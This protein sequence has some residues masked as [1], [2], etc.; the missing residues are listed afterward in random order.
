MSGSF[1]RAG[2][3]L[4][5]VVSSAG[6]PAAAE[7][8]AG[9]APPAAARLDDAPQELLL[10]LVDPARPRGLRLAALHGLTGR[11]GAA[12]D[13]ALLELLG[14]E[15]PAVRAV[16]VEAVAARAARGDGGVLVGLRRAVAAGGSPATNRRA[17]GA[18]AALAHAAPGGAVPELAAAV[19]HPC[20]DVRGAALLGLAHLGVARST[21]AAVA[22]RPGP[23]GPLPALAVVGPEDLVRPASRPTVDAAPTDQ[24]PAVR[25]ALHRALAAAPARLPGRVDERGLILRALAAWGDPSTCLLPVLETIERDPACL[26]PGRAALRAI[27]GRD[28]GDLLA[29]WRLW[30]RAAL[31]WPEHEALLVALDGG[32]PDRVTTALERLGSLPHPR[33]FE[34]IERL[35]GRLAAADAWSTTWGDAQ[36]IAACNALGALQDRRGAAALQRVADACGASDSARAAAQ[37]ALARLDR[38]VAR[39][40]EDDEAQALPVWRAALAAL[41]LVPSP[42]P[43][44]RAAAP[45][46]AAAGAAAPAEPWSSSPRALA[47]LLGALAG[48]VVMLSGVLLALRRGATRPVVEQA[49]E[50]A[51]QAITRALRD[52]DD[53]GPATPLQGGSGER[54]RFTEPPDFLEDERRAAEAQ[55]GDDVVHVVLG[56]TGA[57]ARPTA[58]P[59]AA[60]PAADDAAWRQLLTVVT[61]MGPALAEVSGRS[62]VGAAARALWTR[63][64]P[65]DGVEAALE[66]LAGARADVRQVSVRLVGSDSDLLLFDADAR[67]LEAPA[68]AA[69]A[70]PGGELAGALQALRAMGAGVVSLSARLS[71]DGPGAPP[72]ALFPAPEAPSLDAALAAL[73]ELEPLIIDVRARLDGASS[74]LVLLDRGGA[75]SEPPPGPTDAPVD[76]STAHGRAWPELLV[77]VEELGPRLARAIV[78]GAD[79]EEVTLFA[80][81]DGGLPALLDGLRGLEDLACQVRVR[82][83]GV[84]TD[85]VLLDRAPLAPPRPSW[86]ALLVEAT[87]TPAPAALA[88]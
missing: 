9:G 36:A 47:P 57:H 72:R 39:A 54:R 63:G 41:P 86:R 67:V 79:G 60:A 48:A 76:G 24:G 6:R 22:A 87:P 15:D 45:A 80:D 28:A 38:A 74:D 70:E 52:L 51:A 46:R 26:E 85:L 42:P 68:L 84:P 20:V 40:A 49:A 71:V 13:G 69:P 44:P 17:V 18:A 30:A 34:A 88:A 4:L 83:V 8:P 7:E 62:A 35:V 55:D 31:L 43:P 10:V 29:W 5:L 23:G 73:E 25:A 2:V 16:A 53:E 81:D 50:D 66:A 37:A 61:E 11:A 3:A 32:A 27:V 77:A 78:R 75:A 19:A 14:D 12:V 59:A 56:G 33:T 82:L 21:R 58:P 64:N 1:A 65:T